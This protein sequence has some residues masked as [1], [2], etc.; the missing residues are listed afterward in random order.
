MTEAKD[1]TRVFSV[2]M[3]EVLQSPIYLTQNEFGETIVRA[4][5]RG[6]DF[7]ENDYLTHADDVRI[8]NGGL[9]SFI[10]SGEQE[11]VVPVVDD[12]ADS[13]HGEGKL[14]GFVMLTSVIPRKLLKKRGNR[15][16]PGRRR[17]STVPASG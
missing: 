4:T 3:A 15:L 10:K 2:P 9:D 17:A 12:E 11:V 6:S 7:V 5:S 16:R 1:T 14:L 13:I 8:L